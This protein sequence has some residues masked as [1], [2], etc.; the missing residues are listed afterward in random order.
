MG[1]ALITLDEFKTDRG[2]T[3]DKE[4]TKIS[5]LIDSATDLV[6]TYC[7]RTFID[8]FSADKIEYFD[9]TK[10]KVLYLEEIP[11]VSITEVATSVDGTTYTAL[12]ENTDYFVDKTQDAIFSAFDAVFV[13]T[14]A[15]AS[16]SVK[17]TFK[18]GYEDAPADLKQAV[19]D[20]V[21]YYRTEQFTPRKITSHMTL[22]N[23]GFRA[24][25]DTGL[26]PHI[27]RIL[28]MYRVQ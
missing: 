18:G 4:D 19:M 13:P 2:I 17:V 23:V 7:N 26:P 25:G 8:Y 10:Y 5:Q 3:I 20:I 21:E 27:K 6:K 11:L 24:G 15:F 28:E 12:T 9:G 14:A 16:Q 1:S 22:E